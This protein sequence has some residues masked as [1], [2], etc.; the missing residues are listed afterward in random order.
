M[1]SDTAIDV[2]DDF[3]I[4]GA[5]S[6]KALHA[7]L[8]HAQRTFLAQLVEYAL[9]DDAF[10]VALLIVPLLDFGQG[11]PIPD[12]DLRAVCGFTVRR[13]TDAVDEL[14]GLGALQRSRPRLPAR[15]MS[16]FR[17][18]SQFRPRRVQAAHDGCRDV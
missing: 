18:G 15:R 8:S 14:V 3:T 12:I 7:A 6:I 5:M 17:L 10:L 4:P 2:H 13:W 11:R 9:S 1:R 16:A